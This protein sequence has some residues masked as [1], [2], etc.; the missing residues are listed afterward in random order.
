MSLSS[1]STT[2]LLSLTPEAMR[3]LGISA[4][5][6]SHVLIDARWLLDWDAKCRFPE[7]SARYLE[8]RRGKLVA[9]VLLRAG[10][11]TTPYEYHLLDSEQA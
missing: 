1:P 8:E 2:R 6:Q 5:R 4:A 3:G 10:G 11:E 9:L 7:S